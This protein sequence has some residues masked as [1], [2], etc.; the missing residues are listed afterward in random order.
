MTTSSLE[1][2]TPSV[3][4][5]SC[6]P[7]SMPTCTPCLRGSDARPPAWSAWQSVDSSWL[8]STP[9]ATSSGR[10]IEHALPT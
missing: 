6:C 3:K 7:A 2:K 8:N 4:Y 1:I 10:S 5:P 9:C